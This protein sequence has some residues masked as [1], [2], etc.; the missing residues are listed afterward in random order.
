MVVR[1]NIR[2][3]YD[4]PHQLFDMPGAPKYDWQ[5]IKHD[6]ISKERLFP[7]ERCWSISDASE[8]E[9]SVQENTPNTESSPGVGT[10]VGLPL[11]K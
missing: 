6:D 3:S 1:G 7:L 5:L 4:I 2:E 10:T 9:S 11:W 8:K